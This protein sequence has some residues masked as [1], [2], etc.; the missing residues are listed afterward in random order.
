M[1]YVCLVASMLVALPAMAQVTGDLTITNYRYAGEERRI[2]ATVSEYDLRGDVINTGPARTSLTA[3]IVGSAANIVPVQGILRFGAIPSGATVTST[4]AITLRVDRSLPFELNTILWSFSNNRAPS[5][6]AGPNQTV[7]LSATVYLN[8]SGSTSPAGS[9]ALTY[10]WAFILRPINSAAVLVNPNTVNP[11]FVTD[12]A[13][14]YGIRLT[15]TNSGGASDSAVVY[16]S[17]GNSIPLANPGRNQSVGVTTLV[18]LDGSRSSDV[19]GDALTFLWSFVSRPAGSAAALNLPASVTP[20]FR[21]DRAG[22]YVIQ[23]VVNDGRF[24]SSPEMVTI[25]TRNTAPVANVG[26][27][28]SSTLNSTVQLTGAGSTDVDG[29]PL[30]YLWSWNSVPT[31]STA[32]FSSTTAVNPSFTLDRP[33]TYVAQLTVSD[34]NL[35]STPV[36]VTISTNTVQT[37]TA[38]A[39]PNQSVQQGALVTLNATGTDPQN[40]PLTYLWSLTTRPANSAAVLIDPTSARPTFTADKAGLFVAQLIANNAFLNSAPATVNVTTSGTAPVGNAGADQNVNLGAVV[41]LNGNASSDADGDSLNY[42]W[43][44]MSRPAGSVATLA[45]PTSATPTFVADRLGTYVAQLIVSD[46]FYNSVPVTVT[47]R[48]RATLTFGPTS[49][50]F[51][52]RAPGNLTLT[53]SGPA[54]VGGLTVNLVSTNP[55]VVTVPATVSFA[56]SATTATIA[57]T[58]V[59]PGG[60]SVIRASLLPDVAEATANVTLNWQDIILPANVSVAPA[61]EA[62]FNVSL[63]NAPA[64]AT[65]VTLQ[66]SDITKATLS[67]TTVQFNAGQTQPVAQPRL[68]GL[69]GSTVTITATGPSLNTAVTTAVVTGSQFGAILLPATATMTQGQVLDYPIALTVPAAVGGVTVNLASSAGSVV[70]ISPASVTIP[71]GQTQ[72]PVVPRVTAAALGT[73]TITATASNYGPVTRGIQVGLPLVP[74]AV[75]GADQTAAQG[76]TVAL[77]GTGTDPQSLPLTYAWSLTSKPSGSA[78]TLASTLANP[79]FSPDLPGSYTLQ[80]V[81][82]NGYVSSAPASLTVTVTNRGTLQLPA[83][84]SVALGTPGTL[85]LTLS[86]PAPV[87]GVVVTLTNSNPTLVQITPVSVEI[88]A[89]ATAPVVPVVVRGLELGTVT[90]G[91]TGLGYAPASQTTTATNRGSLQLPAT[92]SLALGTPGTLDL[93]L[94]A[95][96][97]VGGVVVTLTNSNP[98]L[99]ETPVSV[100]IAAGA[101]APSAPVVVRGLELGTVTIGATAWGYAPASQ[102]TTATNRGNLQLPATASVA[103][104]TPGTLALTLSTPAPA[105]GVVV[106]LTN[107]NPTLVETPVSVEIAAGATA[108]SAPVVVRGLELGTVTIGA[109]ARGYALASQTLTATNRGSLL[110]PATLSM[111]LGTPGTLAL[112][113]S[114]PAPVG[115]TVVTLTNSHPTRV[116]IPVSVEFAA[117]ATTPSTPVTVQGLDLGTVT[118]G[119]TAWGYAPASQTTTVSNRGNLQLPATVSMVLGTQGTLALTL[120][121][122]APVGG[123]VVNLVSSN[124]IRV[125]IPQ[126]V[127]F[128]AGATTPS[129]PVVVQGLDLGTATISA[130]AWGYA[131]ASQTTTV[132]ASLSL[133]PNTVTFV[134]VGT[135][136]L[137]VALSGPAPARGLTMNVSSTNPAVATVPSTVTFAPGFATTQLVVTGVAPGSAVIQVGSLELAETSASITFSPP[138]I[139]LPINLAVPVGEQITF[140]ITLQRPSVGTTFVEVTSSDPSRASL[141]IQNVVF[142]EGQTTPQSQARITGW[143]AGS[144]TVSVAAVNLNPTRTVVRVGLGLSFPAPT[145]AVTGTTT[146][147]ILLS[148]SGGAPQGGL[149]VTLTS[150]N[151]GV[152]TVPQT[153]V[154]AATTTAVTVPV[155]GVSAGSATIDVTSTQAGNASLGVVVST[156]VGTGALGLPAAVQMTAGQTMSFPVTLSAPA[157]AGGLVVSLASSGG[158]VSVSPLSVTVPAGQTQS[159]TVPQLTAVSA[160]SANITATGTGYTSASRTITVTSAPPAQVT[161][162][163]G[164]GQSALLNNSFGSPLVAVVRDG[165]GN[166]MSGVTVTFS[167]P[168]SGASAS[169]NTAT[170]VTNASGLATS[171]L[172]VANGMAGGYVVSAA[173]AGVASLANF[174]L[175]NTTPVVPPPSGGGGGGGG[176]SISLAPVTVGQNLQMVM[177]LTLPNIAPTGGQRVTISSSDPGMVMVAGRPTDAG[178]SQLTFNVGE[179]LATAGF[180]VQ[181]MASSGIA[182]LTVT[183]AGLNSGVGTVTL[184][185]S[186]FVL[187]G[188][189]SPALA[190]FTVGLGSTVGLTVAAAR[191]DSSLNFVES[192][193]IRGGLSVPVSIMNQPGLTGIVTP[194]TLTVAG[195]NSSA[196]STFTGSG[197]SIGLAVLTATVPAGFSRPGLGAD[198]VTATVTAATIMTTAVTVGENLQTTT[199]IRMNAPSPPE[200]MVVTITSSEPSKMLFATSAT[201]AGLSSIIINIPAGR[202]AS[203]DFYVQGLASSGVVSFSV[204][205]PGFGDVTGSVTLARSSFVVSGPFGVGT[206]FFTTTGAASTSLNLRST[207]LDASLNPVDPQAVR[208]GL[209]VEVAVASA[210]PA[211]GTITGSPVSFTGGVGTATAQFQPV[212]FGTSL[213]SLTVP[214]G[215]TAAASG[216]TLTVTVR[217]PGLV[218]E[219]NVTVGN[220]L[221]A[222]GTLLLGTP[223]PVGGLTVSLSSN[224]PNLLLSTTENGAGA[225]SINIAVNAGQSSAVYYL[226]GRASSGTATYTANAS[227]YQ[228]RTS[229]VNLAPSGLM[230]TGPFGIGFPLSM[231]VAG[232]V[233]QATITTAI[234]DPATNAFVMGQALAGGLTLNIPLGNSSNARA[235]IPAQAVMNGGT[236]AVEVPVQPLSGGTTLISLPP[237]LAGF[238]LPR[239]STSL[240]V[241]VTN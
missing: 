21:V 233:R 200:G 63:A 164:G 82:N 140:P 158:A 167:A 177:T 153:L 88:P 6:A 72:A 221:Q 127:D 187:S 49:L 74:T 93:T 108:P 110:L 219:D 239:T 180:Y 223:A 103:L 80:L 224:S 73:V 91:A 143:N 48:A 119:A 123:T 186:G 27:A 12:A 18:Q 4:N 228:V 40:Q 28:Q 214:T 86:T 78:A 208:G 65:T 132:G 171:A 10:N 23:L 154:F 196:A 236:S 81:V 32:A 199:N 64:A 54:P 240:A 51:D 170:A 56:Q 197:P 160:G 235:S 76:A 166:V 133:T 238:S 114:A 26:P 141:S 206:D 134:D 79:T 150:S 213:I 222:S 85:S 17:T 111:V 36:T 168:L 146:E 174:S 70:A 46:G 122:P 220:N 106:T 234:L 205:S 99:V 35:N 232:G 60:T 178:S 1:R 77:A 61:G 159:A 55:S 184:A 163:S 116:Q 182:N 128:A 156:S 13:G 29:D 5:A 137:T 189:N 162:S 3:T 14:V 172:P 201:M 230:I 194:A 38:N 105:G 120:S 58:P 118:I 43:S 241:Q 98:T 92:A 66:V 136:N 22:T 191:L 67:L 131:A 2:S 94:S 84:A 135:R 24:D 112:T 218:I 71:A 155:T 188:P 231:T 97:P 45:A 121:A 225:S 19:N 229:T 25:S 102:T 107:S 202:T 195:G 126:R 96:A 87:G 152:A 68:N 149:T 211:T 30:T 39:G 124:P 50:T 90:I 142:N 183:S 95:P 226:Q 190:T 109:T 57:V 16:V 209:T 215:F 7:A 130:T 125:Q 151:P 148:L 15:V 59:T 53:L 11:T 113:L 89:G 47:I 34:G 203:A 147:N 8:G 52:D 75:P 20:Q 9:G 157:G 104:G 193:Q 115:G 100:E 101:T 204:R 44:V 37:P 185:P 198:S 117:G 62:V 33:G 161:A 129:A 176:N 175:T 237:P 145:L 165:Q 41:S 83:T 227:G 31:G 179:G 139:I 181:G 216:G 210:T 212:S 217:V 173:V 207:R 69:A 138:D 192:Q 42:L 169:L 144:V